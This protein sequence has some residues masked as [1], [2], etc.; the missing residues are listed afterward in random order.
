ME[1][2]STQW[3]EIALLAGWI[4]S[5]VLI[6]QYL[7]RRARRRTHEL[8]T[9]AAALTAHYDAMDQIIDDPALPLSALEFL[10][11]FSD[12]ISDRSTC[13]AFTDGVLTAAFDKSKHVSVPGWQDEI[14]AMAR[15][16]PDIAEKFHIAVQSGIIAL[17][18]RWPGNSRKLHLLYQMIAADRRR[19]AMLAEQIAHIGDNQRDRNGSDG[20]TISSGLVPA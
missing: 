20:P 4:V 14:D 19:E 8:K 13:N 3:L 1:Q 2:I 16:R 7:R 12:V 11:V 15:H 6:L 17:F 9:A 5:G 18:F 10:S